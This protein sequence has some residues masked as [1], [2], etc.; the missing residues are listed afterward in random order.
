MVSIAMVVMV[1]ALVQA[2][3]RV[4]MLVVDRVFKVMNAVDVIII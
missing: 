2:T 1:G 4:L 3:E